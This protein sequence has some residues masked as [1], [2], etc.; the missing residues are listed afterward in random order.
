MGSG[1]R[2]IAGLGDIKPAG[3]GD[4][5]S[6]HGYLDGRLLI[7]MPVMGDPRFERSVIYMCAH[8][9]DGAMTY[10][11]GTSLGAPNQPA[12]VN[13]AYYSKNGGASWILLPTLAGIENG[14]P[15]PGSLGAFGTWRYW[16]AARALSRDEYMPATVSPIAVGIGTLLLCLA[17]VASL[18]RLI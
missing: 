16:V 9:A 11:I 5:S 18:F 6:A 2:K 10:L 7:A 1:R 14:Y 4:N 3:V 8:S 12:N 17:V 15:D 13:I